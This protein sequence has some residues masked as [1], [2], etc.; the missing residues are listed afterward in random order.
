[1]G[2]QSRKVTGGNIGLLWVKNGPDALEMGCLYYPRKL[3]SVRLRC[4]LRLSSAAT[5]G[6]EKAR[7]RVHIRRMEKTTVLAIVIAIIVLAAVY[8]LMRRKRS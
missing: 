6:L 7:F 5:S 4:R 8:L 3:T 2:G 1:M